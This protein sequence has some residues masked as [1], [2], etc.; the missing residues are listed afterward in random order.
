MQ[1]S[2]DDADY[3]IDVFSLWKDMEILNEIFTKPSILKVFHSATFDII[4]LQ[5]DFGIYVVNMFDT[6]LAA[7]ALNYSH[8]SLS[9]LVER[10]CGLQLD[11]RFQLA[12]WRIRPIPT[13]M[14]HYARCDTHSLLYIYRILKQELLNNGDNS[15]N[16]LRLVMNRSQRVCLK[17]YE[18][19]LLDANEHVHL[20]WKNNLR[21]NKRQLSA[22]KSLYFWRDNIARF[23]DESVG[24]VLPNNLLLKICEILPR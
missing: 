1:L 24:Y 20:L 7:Q 16:L 2:T 11:K 4:W 3:I 22:L 19:K 9:A 17:R 21:F 15:A 18:K 14:L 10:F 23:E 12:D 13:E 6:Y 8:L 5:R